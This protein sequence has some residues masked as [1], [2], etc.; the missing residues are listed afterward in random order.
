MKK[1]AFVPGV[2]DYHHRGHSSIINEA[3]KMAE[4]VV[5]G[6]INDEGT[7]LKNKNPKHTF[8]Q[9]MKLV[10]KAKIANEVV[11]TNGTVE[12]YAVI[13][14]KYNIN[15]HIVG[16]DHKGTKKAK[17]LEKIVKVIYLPRTEGISSTMLREM[18]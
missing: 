1:I 12:D 6:V 5:V 3:T 2:F 11:E 8:K 9:R 14:K 18:E 16:E 7:K 17:E 13:Y 15:I 10:T 4:Y